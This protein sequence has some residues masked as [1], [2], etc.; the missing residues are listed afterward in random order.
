MKED[1][2]CP[3][4]GRKLSL[5]YLKPNCPDCG[6]DI[7]RY[8]AEDRMKQDAAQAQRE[9]EALWNFFRRIDKAHLIEKHYRKK[10]KSLPWEPDPDEKE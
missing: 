1:K 2:Y 8:N 5:L 6:V 3:C 10:K 9:M 4:C 7:L